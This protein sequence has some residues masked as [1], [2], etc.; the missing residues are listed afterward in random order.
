M[1]AIG[2]RAPGRLWTSAPVAFA[3][4]AAMNARA[5]SRANCIWHAPPYGIVYGRPAAAASIAVV[6]ADVTPWSRPTP[7]TVCGR[8]PTLEMPFSS[9]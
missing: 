1:S 2:V 8:R 3:S 7:Y 4:L 9:K 6:G 5:T